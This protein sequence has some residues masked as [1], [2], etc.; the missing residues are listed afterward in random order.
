VI[1]PRA[2]QQHFNKVRQKERPPGPVI[3]RVPDPISLAAGHVVPVTEPILETAIEEPEIQ[4]E[5]IEGLQEIKIEPIIAP[6]PEI[7]EASAVEDKPVTEEESDVYDPY[8][9]YSGSSFKNQRDL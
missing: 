6:I 2:L 7:K 3:P 4:E 8:G 1:D 9:Y 5:T